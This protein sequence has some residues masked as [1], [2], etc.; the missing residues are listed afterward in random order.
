MNVYKNTKKMTEHNTCG[1][2]SWRGLSYSSKY[3]TVMTYRTN[4][5]THVLKI[6]DKGHNYVTTSKRNIKI[7]GS[8]FSIGVV[9]SFRT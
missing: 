5:D 9:Y 1:L 2:S 3:I 7:D 8:P 4:Q 6:N